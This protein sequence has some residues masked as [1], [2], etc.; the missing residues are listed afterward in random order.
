MLDNL[1]DNAIKYS[2]TARVIEVGTAADAETAFVSIR[3][4]GIGI[5]DGERQHVFEKVYRGR[6][7]GQAGSGLGLASVKRVINDQGGSIHVASGAEGGTTV[8]IGIPRS[9]M[10]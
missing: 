5:P 8:P 10:S 4:R 7:A 6:N 2:G 1:I 3:D 9:E